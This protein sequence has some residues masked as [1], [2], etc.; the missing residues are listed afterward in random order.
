MSDRAV[1]NNI[2]CHSSLAVKRHSSRK[3]YESES[4]LVMALLLVGWKS[5][6]SFLNQSG[7][8]VSAMP[9]TFQHSNENHYKM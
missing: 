2:E 5:G 3:T 4:W 6:V 8:L 1:F 9:D 7:D